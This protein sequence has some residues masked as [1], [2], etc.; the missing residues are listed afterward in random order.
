MVEV[1]PSSGPAELAQEQVYG[2][3]E[4]ITATNV[5]LLLGRFKA[6][7]TSFIDALCSDKPFTGDGRSSESTFSVSARRVIVNTQEFELI[8]TPGFDNPGMSNYSVFAK[9]ANYLLHETRVRTRIARIIYIHRAGDSLESRTLAQNLGVL[10]DVFLGNSGLSRLTVMAVPDNLRM[11]APT[12]VVRSLSHSNLF[13]SVLTKGVQI[14]CEDLCQA[15]ISSILISYP[16]HDSVLLRIQ[17]EHMQNSQADLGRQIEDRLGYYEGNRY[18]KKSDLLEVKLEE[19]ENKIWELTQTCDQLEQQLAREHEETLALNQQLQQTQ[20][21]YASLRSQLQPHENIEQGD[22]VQTLKDLNR[23]IDDLSRSISQHVVDTYAEA[24]FGKPPSDI[25]TAEA[26]DL[27]K[28]KAL[29]GHAEGRSSLVV[30]AGGRGMLVE[31]FLDYATRS[32]LCKHLCMKIFDR[33]HPAIDPSLDMILSA[34]Y[35]DLL[36]QE[37]PA[38]ATKWRA[39]SFKSSYK[40]ETD[41]DAKYHIVEAF[42]S[43]SLAPLILSLF[44]QNTAISMEARHSDCLVD[45]V[46][47]AWDWNSILKGEV[48]LLGDF[49]QTCYAPLRRFEADLMSEFEPGSHGCP[50]KHILGTLGLGLSVSRVVADGKALDSTVILKA[51]VAMKS[52]YSV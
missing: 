11:Q 31:D 10:F 27:P 51:T 22:I 18:K 21:E 12:A 34:M 30:S 8:D 48:V 6:G 42:V 5:V 39:Q 35:K 44:G 13:R 52:L 17:Q 2:Q 50:S 41:D 3:Q 20:K 45:L 7:K 47:R 14:I 1:V 15:S 16:Y 46:Q 28:L 9:I 19:S 25:T 26:R 37:S 36:Q 4:G 33:F 23:S 49:H 43:D 38:V 40:S 24:V 29:L 32:L